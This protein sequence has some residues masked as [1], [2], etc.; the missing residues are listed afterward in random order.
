MSGPSQ[1]NHLELNGATRGMTVIDLS[2][3]PCHFDGSLK[4]AN[5]GGGASRYCRKHG[6]EK[7]CMKPGC[8][9][10]AEDLTHL[11]KDHGRGELQCTS[12]TKAAVNTISLVCKAHM[13]GRFLPAA[14]RGD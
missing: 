8:M 13:R 3:T 6:G 12:C 1:E 10:P 9:K 14:Q 4:D 7:S 11:C 2:F 5:R